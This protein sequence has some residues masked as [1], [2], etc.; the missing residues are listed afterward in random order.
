MDVLQRI[1]QAVR[2]TESAYFRSTP[3]APARHVR[4]AD[5]NTIRIHNNSGEFL[6]K[7]YVVGIAD[8]VTRRRLASLLDDRGLQPVTL[9][10]PQALVGPET[11]LGPGC[12]V[13]GGAFVSSTVSLAAHVQVQYNATIGHAVALAGKGWKQA[14]SD[15]VHLRNG[16]NVCLGKVTYAAVAQDLGYEYTS[17]ESML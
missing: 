11:M 10:H 12:V 5:T 3:T 9:V 16:L 1:G 14:L 7:G 13:M 17:A 4:R 2:K 8:P 6:K 15:D